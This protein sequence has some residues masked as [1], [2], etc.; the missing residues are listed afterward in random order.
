MKVSV[1]TV[2]G[3]GVVGH[4]HTC[5]CD[6]IITKPTPIRIRN[7]VADMWMGEEI[8]EMR[9]YGTPWLDMDM[10]DYFTD[11]L[12]GHD[13][14]VASGI[15][16]SLETRSE[17]HQTR[18]KEDGTLITGPIIGWKPIRESVRQ[19][20][21]GT[22]PK[23]PVE[24]VL[25]SLGFTAEQFTQ[26]ASTN[27]FSM[28]METL[29]RFEQRVLAGIDSMSKFA[30]DFNTTVETARTLFKYWNVP[31]APTYKHKK[32]N[33]IQRMRLKE[34]VLEGHMPIT[35]SEILFREFGYVITRHSVSK[36]K[37]KILKKHREESQ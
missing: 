32:G 2:D 37:S 33:N 13:A 12:R 26:A 16:E 19:A 21:S 14:W 9:N 15:P 35:I 18:Y 11:L 36:A 22:N 7:A 17:H 34:L 10:V 3:C 31:Y 1:E 5:L 23:P 29:N 30:K 28:D 6:V 25:L 20:L 24:M 4:H 8:C 27:R